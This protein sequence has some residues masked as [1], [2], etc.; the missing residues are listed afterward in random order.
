LDLGRGIEMMLGFALAKEEERTERLLLSLS[1]QK[2]WNFG[3]NIV[4]NLV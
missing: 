1:P 2:N 4:D 3:I